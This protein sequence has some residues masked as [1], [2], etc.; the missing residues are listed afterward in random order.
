MNWTYPTYYECEFGISRDALYRHAHALDLFN[1]RRDN[2]C[3]ALDKLIEKVDLIDVNGP[4]ILSAI[5]LLAKL[6]S[7][8]HRV[9]K[10]PVTDA[11]KLPKHKSPAEGEIVA[12]GGS[13]AE[14]V[15]GVEAATPDDR[16]NEEKENQDTETNRL[17]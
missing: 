13:L 5:K 10:A 8:R 9:D 7:E 12:E 15:S 6:H 16:Q 11:G 1:K 3:S 2:V 17:Q 4:V 14:S